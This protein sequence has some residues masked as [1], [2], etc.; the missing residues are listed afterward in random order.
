MPF[1]VCG[2]R[3][4]RVS[5]N[6][7]ISVSWYTAPRRSGTINNL[8]ASAKLP[9]SPQ[10]YLSQECNC[11]SLVLNHFSLSFL[12]F[13]FCCMY[14]PVNG[15]SSLRFTSSVLT[16]IQPL[17]LF[18]TSHTHLGS[19]NGRIWI[20]SFHRHVLLTAYLYGNFQICWC[21][22]R[23]QPRISGVSSLLYETAH[24]GNYS[25]Y[26]KKEFLYLLFLKDEISRD[27]GDSSQSLTCTRFWWRVGLLDVLTGNQM[28]SSCVS[29]LFESWIL[30][31]GIVSA[32]IANFL[33][34]RFMIK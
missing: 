17:L 34:E 32:V 23:N 26:N 27:C 12:P 8:Q 13:I 31:W 15:T 9:T 11:R 4:T 28:I 3:L 29:G 7:S 30:S 24:V 10:G 19:M 20:Y 22:Y 25:H 6:L 18:P 14:V 21:F 5:E 1:C 33:L 2:W 16:R